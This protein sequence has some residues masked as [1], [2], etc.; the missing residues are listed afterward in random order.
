[1]K[2][3]VTGATGAN[4]GIRLPIAK[5]LAAPGFTVLLGSRNLEP[6]AVAAEVG[7]DARANSF[8]NTAS[9]AEGSMTKETIP[10]N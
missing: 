9:K 2:I 1:M 10:Y 7:P 4:Q 6:G 5:D 3:F 8:S